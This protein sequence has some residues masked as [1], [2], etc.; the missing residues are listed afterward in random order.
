MSIDARILGDLL[1]AGGAYVS[2]TA[3]AARCGISRVAIF[4]HLEVLRKEGFD[5]EAGRNRGYRLRG[6]PEVFHPALFN[7]LLGDNADRLAGGV[8]YYPSIDSTNTQA[9][10]ECAAGRSAPFV[11]VAGEQTRGRGRRGRIWHSPPR[12]NLYLSL[13]IRPELPPN[14]MQ[15]ITLFIALSLCKWIERD[16]GIAPKIKWPNDLLIDGRKLAGILTE[17]R[18]DAESF[19]DMTVG[20]GINLNS[21]PG[22]YPEAVA[23]VATSLLSHLG[24]KTDPSRFAAGM[25]LTILD[26]FEEYSQAASIQSLFS[27]WDAYD[28]LR[29]QCVE[30]GPVRGTAEGIAA[31]GA[32]RIRTAEGAINLLQAGEVSLGTR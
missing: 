24:Q 28:A 29:G 17:A 26:A 7:A 19:R 30:S 10:A 32:L 5:I 6:T 9:E 2:G 27:D 11:L 21:S 31:N 12:D 1:N 18:I 8:T 14:R 4:K 25:V 15:A 22:D 13:T 23:P 16:Y 3:I 20:V